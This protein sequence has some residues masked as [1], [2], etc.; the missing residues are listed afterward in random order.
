MRNWDETGS[1]PKC[2]AHEF[3]VLGLKSRRHPREA[4]RRVAAMKTCQR[5]SASRCE[6]RRFGHEHTRWV[7]DD[8]D[9]RPQLVVIHCV[10]SLA[11]RAQRCHG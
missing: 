3:E 10:H 6:E 2:H 11:R 1:Y 9:A 8:K 7:R 4:D 5:A